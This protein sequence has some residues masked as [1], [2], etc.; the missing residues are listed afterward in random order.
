MRI[1]KHILIVTIALLPLFSN[2]QLLL[3]VRA[4]DDEKALKYFKPKKQYEF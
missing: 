4:K 2:A 1:F 3:E